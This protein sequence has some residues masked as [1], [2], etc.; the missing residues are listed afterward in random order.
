VVLRVLRNA[1]P[2][3]EKNMPVFDRVVDQARR[4]EHRKNQWLWGVYWWLVVGGWWLVLHR[5]E[6]CEGW[7]CRR[8]YC[9]LLLLLL[10]LFDEVVVFLVGYCPCTW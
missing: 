10:T 1:L 4:F 7:L 9:S 8:W 5:L 3:D 6:G 2:D